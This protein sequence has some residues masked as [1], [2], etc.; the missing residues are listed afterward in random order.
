M[1]IGILKGALPFMADLIRKIEVPLK[2]DLVA[3]SSYGASTKT[4]G[5]VQILKDIDMGLEGE[6]VLVVEDIVDTGLTLNYLLGAFKAR[7]PASLKVCTLLDKPS[8]REVAVDIKYNGFAIPDR[9][10]VGYGL[11]YAE[12]FRHLPMIAVLKPEVYSE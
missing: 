12:R 4:S 3:V 9:F 7:Q 6:H 5:A 11:D 2:Y 8:R 1:V 10:V